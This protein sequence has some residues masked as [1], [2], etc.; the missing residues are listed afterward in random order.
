MAGPLLPMTPAG[1]M[2]TPRAAN[3]RADEMVHVFV[4][5]TWPVL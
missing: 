3:R 1:L 2:E 5:A 4:E